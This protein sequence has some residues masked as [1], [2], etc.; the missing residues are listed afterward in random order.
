MAY[1]Y[2]K[3]LHIV[4]IVTWFAGLL[5]LV[6]IYIYHVEALGKPEVERD[7]LTGQYKIMARRLLHIIAWPSAIITLILG[8]TLFF[9]Q[10]YYLN[11]AGWM[12]L[13]LTLLVLLYIYHFYCHAIYKKLRHNA[14]NY[15]SRY[16]RI[17]N[18]IAT[19]L[20][21]SIVIV[22][23]LKGITDIKREVIWL[24]VLVVFLFSGIQLY[25]WLRNKSGKDN[26]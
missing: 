8:T 6:R 16:L 17:L 4:F 21:F 3:A 24:A 25:E 12:H 22:A 18:E 15:S 2:L 10:R 14:G 26:I 9:V 20:L 11:L 7:I 19:I 23:V 13:K 5:Y 1:F